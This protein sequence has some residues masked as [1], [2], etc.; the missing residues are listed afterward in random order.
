[1]KF[2]DISLR[3]SRG[4]Q[5]P[6]LCNERHKERTTQQP[7]LL[8]RQNSGLRYVLDGVATLHRAYLLL[9]PWRK[10]NHHYITKRHHALLPA[11]NAFFG[12]SGLTLGCP[13]GGLKRV[14]T[15][16][17][18][19][20]V[21]LLLLPPERRSENRMLASPSQNLLYESREANRNL[22]TAVMRRDNNGE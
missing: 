7:Y 4:F 6:A 13:N 12:V 14:S 22:K 8:E 16:T 3:S 9:Q 17:P 21:G 19:L 20:F 2:H 5:H 11:L 18:S 1:M 10:I 15:T